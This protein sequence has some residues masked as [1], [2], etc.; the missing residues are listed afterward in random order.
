MD[1]EFYSMLFLH[2][3]GWSHIFILDFVNVVYHIDQFADGEL[4]F[5]KKIPHV[6]IYGPFNALMT[7]I[8]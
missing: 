8:C 7:L 2:I 1:T 4:A 6:M 3:L 5:L